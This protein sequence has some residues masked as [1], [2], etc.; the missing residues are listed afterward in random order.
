MSLSEVNDHIKVIQVPPRRRVHSANLFVPCP[1]PPPPFPPATSPAPQER[2]TEEVA[3]QYMDIPTLF[4]SE[5][6]T[7]RHGMSEKASHPGMGSPAAAPLRPSPVWPGAQEQNQS[8]LD[9]MVTQMNVHQR[10]KPI[11]SMLTFRLPWQAGK[12]AYLKGKAQGAAAGTPA[13]LHLIPCP[14]LKA[15]YGSR[16]GVP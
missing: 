14:C 13:A 6:K 15:S 7:L 16:F 3:S 8:L 5:V 9:D 2:L 10:L 4:I 11:K 12:T 1:F